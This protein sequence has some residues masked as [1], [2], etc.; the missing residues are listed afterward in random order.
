MVPNRGDNNLAWSLAI[1]W[2]TYFMP[3][4]IGLRGMSG[5]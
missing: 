5:L 2:G 3:E 1:L 4:M